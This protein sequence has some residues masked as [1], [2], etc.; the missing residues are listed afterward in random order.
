MNDADDER[1]WFGY[2]LSLAIF[3]ALG[4][5]DCLGLQCC[6]WCSTLT[7][8]R[9]RCWAVVQTVSENLYFDICAKTG[10]TLRRYAFVVVARA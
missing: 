5:Y 7:T 10:I 2:V 3:I 8:R 9:R 4:V 6:C 1:E